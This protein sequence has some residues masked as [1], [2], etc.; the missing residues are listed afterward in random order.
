MVKRIV[1]FLMAVAVL[2]ALGILLSPMVIGNHIKNHYPQILAKLFP[3]QKI[4]FKLLS[5]QRGWYTD[6]ASVQL[7]LSHSGWKINGQDK[8]VLEQTIDV[9]PILRQPNG[10]YMWQLAR[11]TTNY[12][13]G[14]THYQG[15]VLLD[16]H[17]SIVADGTLSQ[18]TLSQGAKTSTVGNTTLKLNAKPGMKDIQT[19][20]GNITSW[21]GPTNH[22]PAFVANGVQLHK[23][24]L[25]HRPNATKSMALNI[26]QLQLGNDPAKEIHARQVLIQRKT[27]PHNDT[28][29]VTYR[30]YAK[31]L[32]IGKKP[33]RTVDLD[34]TVNSLSKELVKSLSHDVT[35]FLHPNHGNNQWAVMQD[36]IKVLSKGLTLTINNVFL[37]TPNG[38]VQ[39]A[40]ALSLPKA[41]NLAGILNPLAGLQANLH[42]KVPMQW[43]VAQVTSHQ[44]RSKQQA[45][46]QI[47]TW[48]KQ[49]FL[50]QEGNELL[51]TL[52]Y[53]GGQFYLSTPDHRKL[54]RFYWAKPPQVH[55]H[56]SN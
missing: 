19:T 50:R 35:T 36:L 45:A 22:P 15:T 31:Q 39:L 34:F 42:G 8:I 17:K 40:G 49:G 4:E 51:F 37:S 55:T 30:L 9:G 43:M 12:Q 14:K 25:G 10:G 20:I 46:A 28:V 2:V 38:S 32:R 27:L 1:L 11:I 52:V 54:A 47:A 6:H 24:V 5:Y 16:L 21:A 53:K 7:D 23:T 18:A 44:Q 56:H 29:T 13:Q 3:G 33:N 48:L 41:D 26:T